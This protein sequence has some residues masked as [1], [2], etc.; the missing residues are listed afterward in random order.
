MP[1]LH[2]NLHQFGSYCQCTGLQAYR[3]WTRQVHNTCCLHR[4][5]HRCRMNRQPYTRP[6]SYNPRPPQVF[7]SRCPVS[8]L[9]H[10]GSCLDSR[11]SWHSTFPVQEPSSKSRR[12][13]CNRCGQS[14]P[15]DPSFDL[16]KRQ[17]ER[18]TCQYQTHSIHGLL[19]S[20]CQPCKR[21]NHRSH[22]FQR[23]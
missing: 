4:S 21:P 10:Q 12:C 5:R 18:R 11:F 3:S 19:D 17:L 16:D 9:N 1:S 15:E 22:R 8:S 2:H 7:Y 13:Q 14:I 23:T 20:R 6:R